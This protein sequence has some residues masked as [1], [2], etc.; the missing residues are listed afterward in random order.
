MMSVECEADGQKT[1][2]SKGAP[3]III[4]KCGFIQKK[5]GVI[6]LT[7]EE[8]M[9]LA[10][11]SAAMSADALRTIAVAYR[12]VDASEKGINE[13]DMVF[14][15]IVGMK[16]PPRPEVKG[17]IE[18]C[19]AAGI[20]VKM[21]TGD[22]LET[23][24]SVAREVGLNGK[25]MIGD[26][27][28]A[29]TD[30]ELSKVVGEIAVFA[31]VKPEHKLRIVKA[32]KANGEIV[33]MTGD[34]VNDAPALKEAHIGVAMGRNGTDVCRS[35][36]DLTLKDDNFATIVVAIREGRA[37]F[38][39][40]RKFT[41]YLLSCKYAEIT[42]LVL[43]VLLAPFLGWQ[44]PFLLALQ[45][46]FMNLVTDDLP[47][48]TLSFNPSSSS[49]MAEK[50]RKNEGILTRPVMLWSLI[51]GLVMAFATLSVFFA[52][53]N[54]LGNTIEYA[55]TMA[56]ATL[57]GI[58]LAG[59]YNFISYRKAVSLK[60][61]KANKYLVYASLISIAATL[62]VIY[63]PLNKILQTVPL[64]LSDWAFVMILSFSIIIMFN[65]LKFAN[66]RRRFFDLDTRLEK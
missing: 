59:A 37:I 33:T 19:L 21:I 58:E 16:D 28:E 53:Y 46:L 48:I 3:E 2:Y 50:P 25:A 63:T 52:Y 29:M 64:A 11:A 7:E 9:K 61:L 15:G 18:T 44:V 65:I 34:G 13:K 6:K 10:E 14:L 41:S 66:N 38:K 47:A 4:E 60:L 35:V 49:I 26:E 27:I 8:K 62:A 24:L 45:I 43:G 23:A 12:K 36:A 5:E 22:K 20:K 39:N 57:I 40:I 51:A 31:R 54:I 1:I 17:A 30:H 55:R 42:I 32:L 56:L